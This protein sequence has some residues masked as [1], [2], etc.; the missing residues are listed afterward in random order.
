MARGKNYMPGLD[1]LSWIT[2]KE[3]MAYVRVKTEET[4]KRDWVPY[5]NQ[6]RGSNGVLFKK[7]EID[8]L[9]ESRLEIEAIK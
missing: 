9:I 7:A 5:L 6:Y 3:A 1:E 8:R 2:I 4:F